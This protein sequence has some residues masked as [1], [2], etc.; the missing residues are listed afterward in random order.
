VKSN[1]SLYLFKYSVFSVFS[2]LLV[3]LINS[4]GCDYEF[5]T[6]KKGVDY[7][8]VCKNGKLSIIQTSI[9]TGDTW[10]VEL[11][12]ISFFKQLFWV[13]GSRKEI[14]DS[15]KNNYINKIN[16]MSATGMLYN[17]AWRR[18]DDNN[19][20]VFQKK[21]EVDFYRLKIDGDIDAWDS[22]GLYTPLLKH[23]IPKD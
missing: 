4:L 8:G 2:F 1:V 10:G 11:V 7:F 13:V 20:I 23:E 9:D 14:V 15:G 22:L 19:V 16:K 18:V 3:V 12:Q 17:Y 6:T 21:P 5:H